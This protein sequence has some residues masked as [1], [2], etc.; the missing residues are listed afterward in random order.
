MKRIIFITLVFAGVGLTS[1]SKIEVS[2]LEQGD[3]HMPVWEKDL[4]DENENPKP[5]L[6]DNEITDP[7]ND[8]DGNK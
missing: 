6:D 3:V 4:D 8:P 7:N 1:C 2:P 5:P